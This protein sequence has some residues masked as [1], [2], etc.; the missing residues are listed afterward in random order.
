M[1]LSVFQSYCDPLGIF[2]FISYLYPFYFSHSVFICLALCL[3]F[4][5]IKSSNCDECEDTHARMT[6]R[7]RSSKL[8]IKM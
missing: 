6:E 4:F 1:L 7:E 2:T 5:A 3:L 8:R